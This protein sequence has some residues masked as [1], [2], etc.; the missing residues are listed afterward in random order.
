MSVLYC[1]N[2]TKDS[3]NCYCNRKVAEK[4]KLHVV[5]AKAMNKSRH[6]SV[7]PHNKKVCTYDNEYEML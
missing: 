4:A 3:V 1:H 7:G 5:A 2:A 6:N